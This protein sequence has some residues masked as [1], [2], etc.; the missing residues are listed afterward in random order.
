MGVYSL[1][2]VLKRFQISFDFGRAALMS[3]PLFPRAYLDD[4]LVWFQPA[5]RIKRGPQNRLQ[6]IVFLLCYRFE[7][8]IVAASALN[9]QAQKPRAEDLH[10]AFDDRVLV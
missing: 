4:A 2:A 3:L 7:F 10:A 5:I 8:V 6:P 1:K 9:R